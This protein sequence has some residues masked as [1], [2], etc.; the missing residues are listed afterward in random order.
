MP[1]FFHIEIICDV[2][3]WM[4]V[5]FL[6]EKYQENWENV[7]LTVKIATASGALSRS[8]TPSL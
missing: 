7:Y 1:R 5:N 6:E 4:Q 8:Q 2:P 3:T